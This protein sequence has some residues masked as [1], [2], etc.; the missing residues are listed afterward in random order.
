MSP[1]L[2]EAVDV[3]RD[4]AWRSLGNLAGV[5][6]AERRE[7]H[8]R[9]E[10]LVDGLSVSANAGPELRYLVAAIRRVAACSFANRRGPRYYERRQAI[11]EL[12][13]CLEVYDRSR[14]AAA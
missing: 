6:F 1:R 9:L 5:R 10:A 11:I 13:G 4:I 12:R 3:A 14:R 7:L 8:R 2:A